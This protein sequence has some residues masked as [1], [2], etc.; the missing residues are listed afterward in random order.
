MSYMANAALSMVM[1]TLIGVYL[2]VVGFGSRSPGLAEGLWWVSLGL[3]IVIVLGSLISVGFVATQPAK[4]PCPYCQEKI[5][6]K[7]RIGSGHLQL[8]RLDED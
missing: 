1:L 7:V 6:L 3:G 2:I 8:S 5:L 4:I